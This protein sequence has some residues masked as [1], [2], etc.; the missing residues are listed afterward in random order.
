MDVRGGPERRLSTEGLMLLNYGVR[1]E[2]LGQ[3]GKQT[4][5]S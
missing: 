1:E 3:Q 2:S 5:Q 4:S